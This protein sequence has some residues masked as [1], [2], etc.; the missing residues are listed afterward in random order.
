MS[1]PSNLYAELPAEL[2]EEIFQTLLTAPNLRIERIVSLGHVSP[3]GFW[4]AQPTHEWVAIL[5]GAARLR[6]EGQEPIDM[7]AGSFLHIPAHQRHRIEWT[8][9]HQP[10]IWLA[11]HYT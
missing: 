7:R 3:P 6:F 4:Y 8:Q 1:L 2:P 5:Q 11:I 10:T 9:E